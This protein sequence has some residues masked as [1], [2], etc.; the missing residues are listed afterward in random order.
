VFH[1]YDALD[2]GTQRKQVPHKVGSVGLI[3][4]G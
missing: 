2:L 3:P 4:R 1:R